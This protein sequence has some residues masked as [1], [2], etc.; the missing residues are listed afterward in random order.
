MIAGVAGLEILRGECRYLAPVP[1]M[2]GPVKIEG[3]ALPVFTYTVFDHALMEFATI[4]VRLALPDM[5][6]Y[7]ANVAL[8][9]TA[10]VKPAYTKPFRILAK[11]LYRYF[12]FPMPQANEIR[13]AG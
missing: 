11:H 4:T 12:P 8:N 7:R 13:H 3:N 1:D 9:D 2:F 6:H 5:I 10:E